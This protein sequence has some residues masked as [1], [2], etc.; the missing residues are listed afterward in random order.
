MDERGENPFKIGWESV[1]ANAVPI[2][3]LWFVSVVIVAMYYQVSAFR[4]VL[5]PVASWQRRHG[6]HGAFLT[7]S[8]F[9]GVIPY[10]IYRFGCRTRVESPLR[11]AVAQ[12]FW[13]GF[14]GVICN[15]FFSVQ[16]VWFGTGHNAAT[17]AVKILTDQFGWTVL[18]MAPSNA[19]FYSLLVGDLRPGDLRRS[20][21]DIF[22]RV[23]LPGLL[24][25]WGFGIPSCLAVYSFPS[26]LQIHVLGLISACG[27]IVCV[28]IGRQFKSSRLSS[29]SDS[30][31]SSA[32]ISV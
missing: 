32:R 21:K 31:A 18:V 7:C 4:E 6:W 29:A 5:E 19:I 8:F 12:T 24:T 14:H 27:V 10:L 11:V 30:R 15:W 3:C 20:L 1:R 28:A 2:A 16:A 9:C 26:A 23:Y 13:C 17:V 25:N 22:Q